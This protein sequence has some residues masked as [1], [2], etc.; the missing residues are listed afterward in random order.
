MASYVVMTKAEV[1]RPDT[2]VDGVSLVEYE[3]GV[4]TMWTG[5]T[6]N[7]IF[8]APLSEVHYIKAVD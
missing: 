8:M 3:D 5:A 2:K 1:G 4:L 7:L 6:G